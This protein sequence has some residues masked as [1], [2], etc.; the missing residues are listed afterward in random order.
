MIIMSTHLLH[1][2]SRLTGDEHRDDDDDDDDE[3]S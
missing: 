1:L 3:S 2:Q